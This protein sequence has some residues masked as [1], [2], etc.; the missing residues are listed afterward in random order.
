MTELFHVSGICKEKNAKV[1]HLMKGRIQGYKHL[2]IGVL[3]YYFGQNTVFDLVCN[4]S[5][6]F[7]FFNWMF[8]NVFSFWFIYWGDCGSVGT[9]GCPVTT[10]LMVQILLPV[11]GCAA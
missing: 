1:V 8:F 3:S 11:H 6:L 10:G 2:T 7:L 9:A 5:S 4:K